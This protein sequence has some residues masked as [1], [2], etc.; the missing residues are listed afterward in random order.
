M[1]E[2]RTYEEWKAHGRFVK[3]FQKAVYRSPDGL[4]YYTKDQ[5][6]VIGRHPYHPP[7]HILDSPGLK[8]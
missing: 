7:M 2:Y 1:T 3:P 6:E 5:T 4:E 8:E